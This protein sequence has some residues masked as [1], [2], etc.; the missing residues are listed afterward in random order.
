M[1]LSKAHIDLLKL[2]ALV[3][4]E[5]FVAERKKEEKSKDGD[6]TTFDE[7]KPRRHFSR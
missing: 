2:L 1:K 6:S 5:Q 4:V 7:K 3:A